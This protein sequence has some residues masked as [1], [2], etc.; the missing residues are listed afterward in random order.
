MKTRMLIFKFFH[1]IVPDL[2][3]DAFTTQGDAIEE[4]SYLINQRISRNLHMH[5]AIRSK[6]G[7]RYVVDF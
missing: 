5:Q 4:A 7:Q 6:K 2:V 3:S 1:Q